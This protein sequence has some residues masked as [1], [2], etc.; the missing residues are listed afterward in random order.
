[1]IDISY[2]VIYGLSCDGSSEVH[3]V[4][5]YVIALNTASFEFIDAAKV[6]K[7]EPLVRLHEVSKLKI[8]HAG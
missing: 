4:P 8:L 6:A 7:W 5:W 1:M 2:K 3:N